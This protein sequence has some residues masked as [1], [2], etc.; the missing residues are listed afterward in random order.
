[1]ITSAP[2]SLADHAFDLVG[3]SDA[4]GNLVITATETGV[5]INQ[6][7]IIINGLRIETLDPN[8]ATLP[9]PP[10]GAQSVDPNTALSWNTPS[11]AD[12]TPVFVSSPVDENSYHHGWT[13]GLERDSEG[14]LY[15]LITCRFGTSVHP[16]CFSVSASRR[17]VRM[18]SPQPVEVD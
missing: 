5:M 16:S 12:F 1:M 18:S 11:P 4:A 15:G 9:N 7:N 2:A 13:T 8:A 3:S 6:F 14:N 17:I 10:D